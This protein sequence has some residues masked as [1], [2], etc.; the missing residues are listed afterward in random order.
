MKYLCN[1][2]LL[3]LG[4]QYRPKFGDPGVLKRLNAS[5]SPVDIRLDQ[6]F[7]EVFGLAGDARPDRLLKRVICLE[8]FFI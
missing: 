6:C 5:H 7:D 1:L 8:N 2:F 4:P 3:D